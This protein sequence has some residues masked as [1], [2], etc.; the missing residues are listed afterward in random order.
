[1]ALTSR[2]IKRKME[3]YEALKVEI[4]LLKAEVGNENSGQKA[5]KA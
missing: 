3:E 1:V 4:E 5:Q 2:F